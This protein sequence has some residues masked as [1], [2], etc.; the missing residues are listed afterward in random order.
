MWPTG[1]QRRRLAARDPG[2]GPAGPATVTLRAAAALVAAMLRCAGIAYIVVQVGIWHTF[3]LSAPWRL[4]VPA[5]AVSWA[6]VMATRLRGRGPSALLACADSAVYAALAVAAQACVPPAVRGDTLSWLVVSTTG[7]LMVPAWYAPGAASVPIA[8]ALP[9]AYL[10]GVLMQPVTDVRTAA[11]AAALLL[12]TGVAHVST[13]QVLCRRA[14]AADAALNRADQAA[15]GRYAELRGALARREHERLVHD[16]VLNTLTALARPDAGAAAPASAAAPAGVLSR[17]RQ[18]VEL[19]EAALRGSAEPA[20]GAAGD[21]GDL[22]AGVRTVTDGMRAR[23][24]TVHLAAD[25]GGGPAVPAAVPAAVVAALA[26]ATREALSN[27]AEHAGTGEAW[28]AVRRS[29]HRAQVTVR[30]AGAGFDPVGAG[31]G[32]LGLRRSIAE[33]I[34]ECGGQASVRSAPGQGTEVSL[35]WTDSGRPADPAVAGRAPATGEPTW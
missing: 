32:R 9:A 17:C 6:A 19:L 2:A 20:A 3:Y 28:V 15:R 21:P 30:D 34:A 25:T 35:C 33:R 18:D 5:L 12:V 16:T 27:V 14:A 8:L 4:A 11:G 10:G 22:L 26:G 29:K 23:G 24:L 7:Q 13:R 1:Y 31:Q